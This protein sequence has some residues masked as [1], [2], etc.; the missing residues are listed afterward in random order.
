MCGY[1][2]TYIKTMCTYICDTCVC[3]YIPLCSGDFG[4]NKI[5]RLLGGVR[6]A[7]LLRTVCEGRAEDQSCSGLC[8]LRDAEL[9][10]S[11]V[12]HLAWTLEESLQSQYI[13]YQDYWNRLYFPSSLAIKTAPPAAG[14]TQGETNLQ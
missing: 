5:Q 11:T 8:G 3:L 1:I 13:A 4:L 7:Q 10:G 6:Q 9:L 12:D 14:L 2:C